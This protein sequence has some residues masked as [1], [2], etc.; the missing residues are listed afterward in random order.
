MVPRKFAGIGEPA[1]CALLAVRRGGRRPG[2]DTDLSP[3]ARRRCAGPRVFSGTRSACSR[4]A[5]RSRRTW[6]RASP[7]GA[8]RTAPA[9]RR[10]RRAAAPPPRP[11][12]PRRGDHDDRLARL[13]VADVLEQR[14]AAHAGHVEIEQDQVR[15]FRTSRRRPPPARA[16]SP[17]ACLPGHPTPPAGGPAR[18][19]ERRAGIR[20]GWFVIPRGAD[21]SWPGC[22]PSRRRA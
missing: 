5:S 14:E 17:S 15:A 3:C 1:S 2:V 10:P 4:G 8:D 22:S 20:E 12:C 11:C 19:A 9:G 13:H 21:V 6:R 16:G 18:A 7:R